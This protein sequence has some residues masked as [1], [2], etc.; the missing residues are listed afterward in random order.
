MHHLTEWGNGF[1][2]GLLAG[3]VLLFFLAPGIWLMLF[4]VVDE[5]WNFKIRGPTHKDS[6]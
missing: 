4:E 2:H 3:A 6:K 1:F 5:L